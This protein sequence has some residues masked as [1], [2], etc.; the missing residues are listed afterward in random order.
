MEAL[1]EVVPAWV[2]ENQAA[3]AGFEKSGEWYLIFVGGAAERQTELQVQA[4]VVDA[5]GSWNPGGLVSRP[6]IDM[7]G[8]CRCRRPLVEEGCCRASGGA[9]T[10]RR[11]VLSVS[12]SL[13]LVEGEP[14]RAPEPRGTSKGPT[15]RRP[16]RRRPSCGCASTIAVR[17]ASS[18]GVQRCPL[19]A[20]CSRR[21]SVVGPRCAGSSF[22]LFGGD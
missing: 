18:L 8:P 16:A 10:W 19:K 12:S 1:G 15:V 22:S 17:A 6:A 2:S 14:R 4:V 21:S 20:G 11:K 7:A 5:A 9:S 13:S 3:H